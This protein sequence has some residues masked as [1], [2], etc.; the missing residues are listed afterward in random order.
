MKFRISH[1]LRTLAVV[2]IVFLVLCETL[3]FVVTTPHPSER[4]FQLYVLGSNELVGDYYPNND[5]NIYVGEQVEWYLGVTNDMG[6]V[7][8]I[9]ILVKIGN[10]T[11]QSPNDTSAVGSPAPVA[12]HF[13]R[14]LQDNETW[15]F[16]LFW[17]ILNATESRGVTQILVLEIDNQTYQIPD[18]SATNGYNFRMIFELWTWQTKLDAFGFGWPTSGKN[19][20]VWLQVWFNTTTSVVPPPVQQ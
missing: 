2:F 17:K 5:P 7:Q 12:I 13:E 20:S 14:F 9:S 6:T 11:I 10:Q 4:F 16:P 1:Q 3:V 15:Q 19:S 8:Y 18:W